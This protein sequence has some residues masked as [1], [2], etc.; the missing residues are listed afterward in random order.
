MVYS[1]SAWRDRDVVVADTGELE[2]YRKGTSLLKLKIHLWDSNLKITFHADDSLIAMKTRYDEL[3]LVFD[4]KT[5]A[6]RDSWLSAIYNVQAIATPSNSSAHEC[7]EEGSDSDGDEDFQIYADETETLQ[8]FQHARSSIVCHLG[9]SISSIGEILEA[10]DD[11]ND[12]SKHWNALASLIEHVEYGGRIVLLHW[13]I[14]CALSLKL[15]MANLLMTLGERNKTTQPVATQGRQRKTSQS[16]KSLVTAFVRD[17]LF[18]SIYSSRLGEP[19]D[20][21]LIECMHLI[22]KYFPHCRLRRFSNLADDDIPVVVAAA[23]AK[24]EAPIHISLKSQ[25]GNRHIIVSDALNSLSKRRASSPISELSKTQS[26]LS[27]IMTLRTMLHTYN[28]TP[29]QFARQCT[30]FHHNQ[31][32][33]VPIWS[34]L[35]VSESSVSSRQ[36]A[37]SDHFNKLTAYLVWSVLAEDTAVD[38]AHVIE[39]ITSIAVEANKH[40]L[41]NFHLV[42][43]CIGCLG[44]TPLMQSRLPLTWKN[45]RPKSKAQLYEL[46]SLCDDN[47]G[48][49][50]LR[51]KQLLTSSTSATL[52]F[53]G[54]IGSTLERLRATPYYAGNKIDVEK[55]E[56]QYEALRV[57]EN[58]LVHSYRFE[59]H[60]DCQN[61]L[62]NLLL[63]CNYIST[64]NLQKRS[65]ELQTNEAH[66]MQFC[67]ASFGDLP[68]R[69]SKSSE[70]NRIMPFTHSCALLQIL[71][72]ANQ[73]LSV[74]VELLLSNEKSAIGKIVQSFYQEVQSSLFTA[75]TAVTSSLLLDGFNAILDSILTSYTGEC[76]EIGGIDNKDALQDILYESAV[77]TIFPTIARGVY[78]KYTVQYKE[79]DENTR[80]SLQRNNT[81]GYM[82]FNPFT[83]FDSSPSPIHALKRLA[84]IIDEI[85]TTPPLAVVKIR[86]LLS[87]STFKTP[88][89]MLYFI[90]STI[91]TSKVRETLRSALSIYKSSL[92][93]SN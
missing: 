91:D 90:S 29:E 88:I 54:I 17:I 59:A 78:A 36:K 16:Q 92:D 66:Q 23:T 2:V 33:H 85:N 63:P 24:P 55:M 75:S 42:M 10:E 25:R 52:P 44:D 89:A 4:C 79:Q 31:L 39:S 67:V 71:D 3:E 22:D 14:L 21:K 61:F 51:K 70:Q 6:E 8:A 58:A 83:R 19:G 20:Q 47:G 84:S 82:M 48:F 34:F 12:Y 9:S 13:D 53:L 35:A 64:P 11:L 50:T 62:N 65:I 69:T 72:S 5:T 76:M 57:V 40:D 41:C 45:V 26:P 27:T 38:R 81:D 18:H 7:I 68:R 60:S 43:A 32:T 93:A 87:S 15:T 74:W 1:V 46:R 56:R 86:S 28:M 77:S 80:S 30:L 73:R 37:I 49:E